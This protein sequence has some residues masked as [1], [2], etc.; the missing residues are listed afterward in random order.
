MIG[1]CASPKILAEK[2]A[3]VREGQER[4]G[5][6]DAPRVVARPTAPITS[7]TSSSSRTPSPTSSYGRLR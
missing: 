4:A 6:K 5:R 3:Y 7:A 2:L 1:H